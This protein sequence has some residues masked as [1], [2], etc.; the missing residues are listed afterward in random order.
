MTVRWLGVGRSI[1]D[2]GRR[3]VRS[4]VPVAQAAY[5]PCRDSKH[6]SPKRVF[7]KYIM[8]ELSVGA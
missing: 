1:W 4:G 2:N 7:A 3:R 5:D 6:E 8:T